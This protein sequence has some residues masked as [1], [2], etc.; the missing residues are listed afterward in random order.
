MSGGEERETSGGGER[1]TT[2]GGEREMSGGEERETSRAGTGGDSG[3][4]DDGRAAFVRV[5]Y[6]VCLQRGPSWHL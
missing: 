5:Y 6:V 2:G 1:E 3:A 4:D